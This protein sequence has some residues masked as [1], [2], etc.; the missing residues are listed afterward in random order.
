MRIVNQRQSEDVPA[1]PGFG[2]KRPTFGLSRER[3]NRVELNFA[4]RGG[5]GV[6]A[7]VELEDEVTPER[8]EQYIQELATE[9]SAG[10][11]RTFA[12]ATSATGQLTW[13]N[14]AEVTAFTARQAK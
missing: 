7:F 1:D 9:I 2:L 10:K 5:G 3:V 12:D 8:L 6:T 11:G 13:V 4:L 14:L